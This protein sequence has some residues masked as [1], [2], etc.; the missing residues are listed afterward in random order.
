MIIALFCVL[1]FGAVLASPT[2]ENVAWN[3]G[4]SVE[5][6]SGTVSGHEAKWPAGS[7]VSEYLGIPFAEPPVGELRWKR[8]VPYKAKGALKGDKFVC[9]NINPIQRF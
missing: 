6:T 2:P 4:Q 9:L 1:W 8:P 3:I 7:S 5:T